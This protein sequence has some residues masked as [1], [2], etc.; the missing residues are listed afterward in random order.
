MRTFGF[1]DGTIPDGF[2][3]PFYFYQEFMQFNNFFNEAQEMM[4]DA[5]FQSNRFFRDE[6]LK[7]FRK[8]IVDADMPDWM[9]TALDDMHQ[10]FPEGTSVR[11]RSSTNN[12]D[13]PGFN[14]AGLYTS[15]TQHPDEGHISKSIKQVYASLWNLR[16]F[17]EREFNRVNHFIASMGVLCHPNYSDEKANGVGVSVDPIYNTSNTFYL[18]SQAGEELVTNPNNTD[19]PEEILLDKTPVSSTD[20]I[21]IQRS[22]LIA[23]DSLI[24]GEHYLDQ[25]R[26]YLTV[27]HN[28]FEELYQAQVNATFAMDIE[29]KITSD[30]RLI[31]KQARPWVS[32]VPATDSSGVSMIGPGLHISPNPALDRITVKCLQCSLSNLNLFSTEGKL[33]QQVNPVPGNYQK[34]EIYIDQLP[35]GIYIVSGVSTSTGQHYA[36]KFVKK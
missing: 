12:E 16:A 10:S 15:K 6:R 28:E 4:N 8:S 3:I 19:I 36:G 2:G 26:D 29:Y 30:D 14:G 5:E 18:N 1:P 9:L 34:V 13:L 11:C 27:I 35:T 32:F 23:S 24:M 7:D 17:E 22:N 33:L 31:I 20:Y 25:M 21:I